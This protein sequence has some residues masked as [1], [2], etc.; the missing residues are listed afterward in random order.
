MYLHSLHK[1]QSHVREVLFEKYFGA[2]HTEEPFQSFGKQSVHKQSDQQVKRL[3]YS[4][5]K[6]NHNNNEGDAG[7]QVGKI[8]EKKS[9]KD[10]R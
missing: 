5:E 1:L 6:I 9:R 3:V 8:G 10:E 4:E 2:R 7:T